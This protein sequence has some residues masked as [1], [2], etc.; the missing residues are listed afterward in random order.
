MSL[1]L[2]GK[3]FAAEASRH[4]PDGVLKRLILLV[5]G[6]AVFGDG[7]DLGCDCIEA[8]LHVLGASDRG[9][10]ESAGMC[11]REDLMMGC[12]KL[13]DLPLDGEAGAD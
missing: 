1:L 13:N 4:I 10:G 12:R 11:R 9:R 6:F 5:E 8:G 3:G 7:L 2:G